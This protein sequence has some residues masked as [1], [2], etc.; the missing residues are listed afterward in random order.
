MNKTKTTKKK[1]DRNKLVD[2]VVLSTNLAKTMNECLWVGDKD[3]N[4]VYVNPTFE[5]VT[6]YALEECV[7]KYC[8]WF[9]TEEGKKIIE[10]HHKLRNLGVSSQYEASMLTKKGKEVPLLI[11]GAP[12]QEGGTMGIF[13]NLTKIKELSDRHKISEQIIRN[14]IEAIVILNKNQKIQL[15]NHGAE[16]IFGYEEEEVIGKDI[17]IVVGKDEVNNAKKIKELVEEKSTVRN[18]ETR[19]KTKKGDL[20]DVSLTVSKVTEDKGSFVGYLATYR[21]ITNQKKVNSELQKRFEAIQDAYKELG[22]QKRKSDY[23]DEISQIATSSASLETLSQL[24][25]SAICMLTKCDGATLRLVE[26]SKPKKFLSLQSCLGVTSKWLGRKKISFKGSLGEE[27][28]ENKRPIIIHDIASSEKHGGAK[29][30]RMHGFKTLIILP[31][32]VANKEIGTIGIYA[33]DP[34]KFRMIE[35][36]FLEKFSNQC[37]LAIYAKKASTVKKK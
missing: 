18:Y 17:S 7:G 29:L 9:F 15:W 32:I 19:R 26:G 10:D 14:S 35:T 25:I 36:D 3:H 21:D 13:T 20:I 27:S 2:Q 8:T 12:T 11:S 16:K 23:L 37:A 6:G 34:G 1:I 24:I 30:V 5:K 31:L 28:L 4:T 22:L 33:T